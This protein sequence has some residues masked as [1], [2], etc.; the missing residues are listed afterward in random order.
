MRAAESWALRLIS[1][2]REPLP[3]HVPHGRWD[4]T[5]DSPLI[6]AFFLDENEKLVP[7]GRDWLRD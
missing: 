7:T 4:V 3:L 1:R 2:N 5:P 6:D